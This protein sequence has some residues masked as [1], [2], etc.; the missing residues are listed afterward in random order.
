[1]S[2]QQEV[3]EQLRERITRLEA[4]KQRR[5]SYNQQEAALELNMSVN[6]LRD[7]RKA[8]CIK[9]TLNGR[10]W[11][12][13]DQRLR[14][15]SPRKAKA[16]PKSRNPAGISRR[17]SI[18]NLGGGRGHRDGFRRETTM[19]NIHHVD[20]EPSTQLGRASD[21]RDNPPLH[22]GPLQCAHRAR[23]RWRGLAR[24]DP[25][26]SRLGPRSLPCRRR[27]CA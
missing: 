4:V 22:S 6:K 3:I 25:A 26:R 23:A 10:I 1:M 16:P 24:P 9:G 17:A 2:N 5:R 13:T 14:N 15:I 12:Y 21:E 19:A 8:G 11:I 27:R 7:E 20:A 18:S